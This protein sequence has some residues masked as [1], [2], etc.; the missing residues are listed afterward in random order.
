MLRSRARYSTPHPSYLGAANDKISLAVVPA[1]VDGKLSS[2]SHESR[3]LSRD[4]LL[5]LCQGALMALQKIWPHLKALMLVAN[6]GFGA[7]DCF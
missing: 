6:S 3:N 4:H 7:A 2:C 1:G 5:D